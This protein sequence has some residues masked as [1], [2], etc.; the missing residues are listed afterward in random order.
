MYIV[1][2]FCTYFRPLVLTGDFTNVTFKSYILLSFYEVII[3][4]LDDFISDKYFFNPT[5][6]LLIESNA[7]ADILDLIRKKHLQ[8]LQEEVSFEH[9]KNDLFMWNVVYIREVLAKG[10]YKQNIHLLYNKLYF[11]IAKAASIKELQQIELEIASSYLDLLIYDAEVTDT[12][13]VNKILQYLHINIESHISLE[14]L[15]KDLNISIGYASECFKRKMGITLMQYSRKIKVERAKT[16]LLSTS[17]SIL[18]ISMLLGFYDQSHFTRTF[19]SL[20]G[21]T[22]TEYRNQNYL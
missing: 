17:K 13:V 21:V 11:K 3:I 14:R 12:F 9:K 19:K 16:L 5:I 2:I 1:N 18:E 8:E 20:T 4:I 6:S 22:P 10:T 7:K 15:S